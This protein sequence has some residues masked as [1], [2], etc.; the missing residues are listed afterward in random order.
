MKHFILSLIA[1]TAAVSTLHAHCGICSTSEHEAHAES[2]SGSQL[3][4]YF[5]AQAGLA[6][7]NL[8][9]AQTAAKSMLEIG[10]QKSC[11]LEEGACCSAELNAATQIA[12]A[13]DIAAAR[14]AFKSWSDALIGKLDQDGLAD[15]A[16][17]KMHCPM[18]FN[19]QGGSWL[20]ADKDLKNP[21][22]GSMMQTCGMQQAVYGKQ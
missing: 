13:K 20:Q 17:V 2:C 3:G 14:V 21:Y 4:A 10:D 15:G 16:A 11:S 19:N 22:Y 9:A 5:D 12:E 8:A 7:D 1:T 6:G 18:A